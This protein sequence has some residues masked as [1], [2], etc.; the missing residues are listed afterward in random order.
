MADNVTGLGRLSWLSQ[1]AS[2]KVDLRSQ[3]QLYFAGVK[4]HLPQ[5]Q[6]SSD[7]GKDY[8]DTMGSNNGLSNETGQSDQFG[9]VMY[10]DWLNKNGSAILNIDGKQSGNM[11][12]AQTQDYSAYDKY[13]THPK[14]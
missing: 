7:S 11:D 9:D 6:F 14:P 3:T 1:D 8:L 2:N 12:V 5:N 13:Y 4:S 10:M